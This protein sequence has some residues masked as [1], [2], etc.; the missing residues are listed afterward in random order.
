[1]AGQHRRALGRTDGPIWAVAGRVPVAGDTPTA[2]R[3]VVE[4]ADAAVGVAETAVALEM[5]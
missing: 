5:A 3:R 4:V 1:M 2:V